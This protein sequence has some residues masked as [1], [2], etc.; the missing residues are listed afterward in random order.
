MKNILKKMIP[1]RRRAVFTLVLGLI[2]ST[3]ASWGAALGPDGWGSVDFFGK[4]PLILAN[5][6]YPALFAIC[7]SVC[8]FIVGSCVFGVDFSGVNL[9]LAA[10][11]ILCAMGSA[12]C[13]GLFLSVFGLI[14]DSMHLVLNVVSYLLMIFTGAE[15]PVSQLP[16]IGRI[17]SQLMPL[18][19]SISAMNLLFQPDLQA[20]CYADHADR[21]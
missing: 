6:L 4:L 17:I 11:A 2:F 10:L 9:G 12:A 21:N 7:A 3:L 18:T 1:D 19:K 8:G 16:L 15:F 14:S 20:F 5:G 13:F